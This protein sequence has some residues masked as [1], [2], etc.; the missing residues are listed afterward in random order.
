MAILALGIYSLIEVDEVKSVPDKVVN[1]PTEK[2]GPADPGNLE[3]LLKSGTNEELL[4]AL[5]S[6]EGLN[7]SQNQIMNYVGLSQR[8][9]IARRLL[10]ADIGE[11]KRRYVTMAYLE[12]LTTAELINISARLDFDES[13]ESLLQAARQYSNDP[14]PAIA[15]KANLAPVL[16]HLYDYWA[17]R[18][19][20]HLDLVRTQ[21]DQRH[22]KFVSDRNAARI[23]VSV[24]FR[25]KD[26]SEFQAETTSLLMHIFSQFENQATPENLDL[27]TSFRDLLFFGDMELLTL[28]T[29]VL[30]DDPFASE[31][32]RRFFDVL[33]RNPK[34][35]IRIYRRAITVIEAYKQTG[36]DQLAKI[37][38]KRLED[39]ALRIEDAEKREMVL[40][41]IENPLLIPEA[42][43]IAEEDLQFG[44]PDLSELQPG[45]E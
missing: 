3:T 31:R 28:P 32:T 26:D 40:A 6:S 18:D 12:S 29:L 8:A 38:E 39:T 37:L 19:P 21:F 42:E 20:R 24:V 34:A 16:A 7:P 11:S 30:D 13:R 10:Q 36:Q 14:D 22:Q 5:V 45:R 33:A 17:K 35:G 23:F 25:L 27:L 4:D 1:S 44:L 43:D 41:E 15:A 2:S 9:A